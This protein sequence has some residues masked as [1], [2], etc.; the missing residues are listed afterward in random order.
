M[1]ELLIIAFLVALLIPAVLGGAFVARNAARRRKALVRI[2]TSTRSAFTAAENHCEYTPRKGRM[3]PELLD[4]AGRCLERIFL[5]RRVEDSYAGVATRDIPSFVLKRLEAIIEQNAAIKHTSNI[6]AKIDALEDNVD[7]LVTLVATDPL[8][9]ATLLRQANSPS[10]GARSEVVSLKFAIQRIG[11]ANLK[12]LVYREYVLRE[13]RGKPVA[14]Q[15]LFETIWEHALM[16]ATA[17]AYLAPAFPGQDQAQAYT[18]ALL[19]DIGKFLLM[20]S[21]VVEVRQDRCLRPY[22]GGFTRD[23]AGIWLHDHALTGRIAALK[24]GFAGPVADAIGMHH[25]PELVSLHRFKAEKA[26]LDSLILT[27]IANQVAKH[28]SREP[29]LADYIVPLHFT[30]HRLVDR[31]ALLAILTR[32]NL[33]R[34]LARIKAGMSF[35]PEGDDENRRRDDPETRSRLYERPQEGV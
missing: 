32:S 6:V 21:G 30:Y 13:H 7:E 12:N 19:H 15:A 29:R 24:W 33:V 16:C 34:E 17:A 10:F 20:S 11:L 3:E 8:L 14:D 31:E 4:D 1:D 18:V 35:A 28:F 26:L 5:K 2:E 23:T 25:Y 22:L 27:H 9:S